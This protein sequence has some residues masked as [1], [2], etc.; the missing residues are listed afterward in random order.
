MKE[1]GKKLFYK[2]KI[3]KKKRNLELQYNKER[4]KAEQRINSLK[5]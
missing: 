3:K 4:Q 1:I 5:K 2:L